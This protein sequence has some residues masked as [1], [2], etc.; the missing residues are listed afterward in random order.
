MSE[1]LPPELEAR[2]SQIFDVR[3]QGE[4]LV[5]SDYFLL[6]VA[7]ILVPAILVAIGAVL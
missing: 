3:E 6:V 7:T 4:P 1:V 2:C 5:R